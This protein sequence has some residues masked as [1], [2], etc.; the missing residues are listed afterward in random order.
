MISRPNRSILRTQSPCLLRLLA[1]PVCLQPGPT[2]PQPGP[3]RPP[4]SE[5][6]AEYDLKTHRDCLSQTKH[7]GPQFTGTV[8]AWKTEAYG[9][10]EFEIS[11]STTSVSFRQ[12]LSQA[13]SGTADL[14]GIDADLLVEALELQG[15]RGGIRA[16]LRLQSVT[17]ST[18]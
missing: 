14:D 8:Y 9:F 1:M 5:R 10:I 12:P 18:Q 4:V 7:L 2:R 3:A 15:L 17:S 6:L 16:S 13:G 11:N